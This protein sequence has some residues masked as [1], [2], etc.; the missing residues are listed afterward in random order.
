MNSLLS[1]L[2]GKGVNFSQFAAMLM[3]GYDAAKQGE[4]P[5]EFIKNLS[6][7][8]PQLKSVDLNDLYGSAVKLAKEKGVDLDNAT[9][10][11]DSI[12]APHMNNKV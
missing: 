11:I 7:G 3:R 8:Y 5:Q 10:Q 12:F 6:K 9:K 2:G 4:S 1:M